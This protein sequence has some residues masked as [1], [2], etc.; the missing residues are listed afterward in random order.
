MPYSKEPSCDDRM[1]PDLCRL[2]FAFAAIRANQAHLV[3]IAKGDP[4][5]KRRP[6]RRSRRAS[7]SHKLRWSVDADS[8][9]DNS[10]FSTGLGIVRDQLPPETR[11]VRVAKPWPDHSRGGPVVRQKWVRSRFPG[12]HTIDGRR[13]DCHRERWRSRRTGSPRRLRP[14]GRQS[15]API[16]RSGCEARPPRRRCGGHV[17]EMYAIRSPTWPHCLA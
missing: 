3:A 15:G 16:C 17:G 13:C 1:F 2:R 4:I 11:P 8:N 6:L 7:I 10:E 5:A 9:L 14:S 12:R